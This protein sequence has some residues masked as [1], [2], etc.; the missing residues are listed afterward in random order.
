MKFRTYVL[1]ISFMLFIARVILL[2]WSVY[3]ALVI[4]LHA[5][6]PHTFLLVT[7]VF[8]DLGLLNIVTELSFDNMLILKYRVKKMNRIPK[9]I[10]IFSD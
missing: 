10:I 9:F 1:A 4:R 6:S 8:L 7:T 5:C 2:I 3:A